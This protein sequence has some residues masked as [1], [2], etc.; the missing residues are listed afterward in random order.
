MNTSYSFKRERLRRSGQKSPCPMRLRL[1]KN[2][3]PYTNYL[4][5]SRSL[6]IIEIEGYTLMHEEKEESRNGHTEAVR[7]DSRS[8]LHD[9]HEV[10]SARLDFGRGERV[11][12]ASVSGVHLQNPDQRDASAIETWTEEGQQK[13]DASKPNEPIEIYCDGICEPNPG[14]ACWAWIAKLD[15]VAIASD[16][17]S[18]GNGKSNNDAEYCAIGKAIRWL[19]DNSLTSAVIHSDSQLA[20]KQIL[21]EYACN[22]EHLRKYRDRVRELLQALPNVRL[23]W[24]SSKQNDEA[25]A[26]TRLAYKQATGREPRVRH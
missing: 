16:F 2:I 21:G 10:A 24:I 17:G 23:L 19:T 1:V 8:C 6:P 15:G 20:V 13:D 5:S 26:L 4:A 11:A 3:A 12:R 14:F 18:L 25:D 22:K 7:T 9:G